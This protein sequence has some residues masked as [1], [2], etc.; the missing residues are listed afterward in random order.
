MKKILTY[1]ICCLLP[2]MGASDILRWQVNENTTVDGISIQQF[3]VPYP[4][5]DDHFP[6]AR[7]K[8]VS[9]DGTSSTIL[10]IYF[11]DGIWEDGELGMELSD[12][13]SGHWGA[14]APTGMNSETG[15]NTIRRAQDMFS[16]N[17]PS[18]ENN[19]DVM[20]AL[21]VMELGYNT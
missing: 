2:F 11:G 15:H 8:L 18:L 1:L 13:G 5:D 6:A 4:S 12:P 3:L 21:F 7:V 19:P 10:R 16:P 14:G 17:P 20:E 9:S